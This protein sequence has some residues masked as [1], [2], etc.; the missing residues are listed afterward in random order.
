MHATTRV[1]ACGRN[2]GSV[3]VAAGG[4]EP[5]MPNTVELSEPLMTSD[6]AL[7]RTR[8]RRDDLHK[9]LQELVYNLRWSWDPPTVDLLRA[10]APEPWAKTHNPVN[11]L[12]AATPDS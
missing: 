5:H 7:R 8:K 4:P 2:G 11:V 12:K 9:M 6:G 10:I 3:R 1:S